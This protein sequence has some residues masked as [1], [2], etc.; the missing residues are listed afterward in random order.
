MRVH[1]V[2]RTETCPMHRGGH[3][4]WQ[5]GPYQIFG[6]D[7]E[8]DRRPDDRFAEV[9][10]PSRSGLLSEEFAEICQSPTTA[11]DPLLPVAR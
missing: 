8:E 4:E 3:D 5:F 6:D 9:V 11:I 2:L 10:R 1:L 7:N